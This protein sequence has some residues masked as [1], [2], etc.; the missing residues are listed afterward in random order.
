MNSNILKSSVTSLQSGISNKSYK[1]YKRRRSRKK[2]K[3]FKRRNQKNLFVMKNNYFNNSGKEKFKKCNYSASYK[4]PESKNLTSDWYWSNY[5][6]AFEWQGKHLAAHWKACALALQDENKYLLQLIQSTHPQESIKVPYTK[7]TL[8][9]GMSFQPRCKE[10]R[11]SC[12][13]HIEREELETEEN[14]GNDDDEDESLEDSYTLEKNEN[15]DFEFEMSEE[16]IKFF[17]ESF[18]HKMELS[19]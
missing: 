8:S 14:N 6:K 15:E 1:K 7:Q 17:Q 13:S 4:M 2:I 5:Q 18:K 9:R 11:N 10:Y 19:K 3:N 12:E 16:M